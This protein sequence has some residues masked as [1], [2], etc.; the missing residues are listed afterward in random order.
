[1]ESRMGRK[2]KPAAGEDVDGLYRKA[3]RNLRGMRTLLASRDN[4]TA[5]LEAMQKVTGFDG[6]IEQLGHSLT[7]HVERE[8]GSVMTHTQI[9]TNIFESPLV[10]DCTST[11]SFDPDQLRRG[12]MTVYLITPSDKLEVWSG[13]L[14]VQLGT[15]LRVITRGVP[16][17]KTPVLFMVD[18]AAHIGKMRVLEDAV[19]LMRGMGVRM[20]LFFQSI[21]QL[22]KVFGER[23]STVLDNLGTLQFFNIT[24]LETAEWLSK[25]AG[26]HTVA[27]STAGDNSGTSYSASGGGHASSQR[28]SNSGTSVSVSEAGRSLLKPDEILRMGSN[29]SLLFHKNLPVILA[30][31]IKYYSDRAFRRRPLLRSFGTGRAPGRGIASLVHTAAVLLVAGVLTAFVAVLPVPHHQQHPFSLLQDAVAGTGRAAESPFPAWPPRER[32]PYPSG[33]EPMWSFDPPGR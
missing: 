29:A 27:V 2:R 32:Q 11:T 21:D 6:V 26:E 20:W 23:A 14:R 4:Y 18:E 9:Y 7:W 19:T 24:S 33:V 16:T 1:M 31:R 12:K 28:G 5:S 13:L 10:A 17:E 30:E 3:A 15:L 8:L 22:N 25:R